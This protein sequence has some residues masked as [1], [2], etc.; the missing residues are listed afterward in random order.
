VH[1][2]LLHTL[3]LDIRNKGDKWKDLELTN[4]LNV[5]APACVPY[6]VSTR[7]NL[8]ILMPNLDA[9]RRAIV[10]LFTLAWWCRLCFGKEKP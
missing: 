8:E 9:L 1:P 7:L 4:T 10:I 2:Q 3:S 6:V 5:Q